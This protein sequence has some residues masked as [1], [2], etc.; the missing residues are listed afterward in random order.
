MDI[1]KMA[2]NKNVFFS[3]KILK[4]PVESIEKKKKS[5]FCFLF[6]A[7]INMHIIINLWNIEG[8]DLLWTKSKAIKITIY[9]NC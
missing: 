3:P 6:Y 5:W 9:I 2:H 1:Q 7:K 8:L 4:S